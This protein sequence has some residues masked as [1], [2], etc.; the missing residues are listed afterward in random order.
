MDSSKITFFNKPNSGHITCICG[1]SGSGKSHL[2]KQ[3]L[4]DNTII[5]DGDA[6]RYWINDD[7][8]YTEEDR[9]TNNIRIA[10][11]SALLAKQGYNI[12]ISTVRA[13]IAAIWL[14]EKGFNV[15][16]IKL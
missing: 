16:L 15:E 14:K 11:I 1:K 12:I 6:V 10:K 7:L 2:A 5:L 4:I 13:D 3:L 9:E 8:S